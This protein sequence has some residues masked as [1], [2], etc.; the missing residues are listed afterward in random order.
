MASG[1]SETRR[2]YYASAGGRSPAGLQLHR[3][4]HGKI[5]I[6]GRTT[7]LQGRHYTA[8]IYSCIGA[9]TWRSLKRQIQGKESCE[10]NRRQLL[11]PQC[12]VRFVPAGVPHVPSQQEQLRPGPGLSTP[13]RIVKV[14]RSFRCAVI[15]YFLFTKVNRNDL[16]FFYFNP[17][18]PKNVAPIFENI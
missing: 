11:P 14:A 16:A 12:R 2:M 3:P 13:I 1:I 10:G 15:G 18:I 8:Q 9:G 6:S 4:L 5:G 7:G 17:A